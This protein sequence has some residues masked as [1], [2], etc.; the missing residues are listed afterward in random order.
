MFILKLFF[1]FG[2]EKNRFILFPVHYVAS[3]TTNKQ[4]LNLTPSTMIF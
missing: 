3:Q 1:F 2:F 4:K